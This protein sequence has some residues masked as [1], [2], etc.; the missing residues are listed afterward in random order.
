VRITDCRA[1]NSQR[2]ALDPSDRAKFAPAAK[3]CLHALQMP[4]ADVFPERPN[5]LRRQLLRYYSQAITPAAQRGEKLLRLMKMPCNISRVPRPVVKMEWCH[6]APGGRDEPGNLQL[7]D[8]AVNLAAG[9]VDTRK[10]ALENEFGA[11]LTEPPT[12][13]ELAASE[14]L[15]WWDGKA[16]FDRTGPREQAVRAQYP[17]PW[18]VVVAQHQRLLRTAEQA[19]RRFTQAAAAPPVA[20]VAEPSITPATMFQHCHWRKCTKVV[21]AANGGVIAGVG[22]KVGRYHYCPPHATQHA[23]V[24][25]KDNARHTKKRTNMKTPPTGC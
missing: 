12:K 1:F 3:R 20:P 4:G 6:V 19:P 23:D 17:T 16:A 21:L 24:L 13:D 10:W 25:R 15:P 5:L 11:L 18:P 14:A 7:L 22:K 2:L 9:E 8:A